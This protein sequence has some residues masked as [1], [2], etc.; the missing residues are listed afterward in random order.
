MRVFRLHHHTMLVHLVGEITSF[1][2]V[3]AIFGRTQGLVELISAL[4]EQN[5]FTPSELVENAFIGGV[6]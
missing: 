2:L 6:N 1:Q 4:I 3:P 5:S